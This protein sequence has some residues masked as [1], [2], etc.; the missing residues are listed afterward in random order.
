VDTRLKE[1]ELHMQLEHPDKSALAEHSIDLG[2]RIQ[3]YDTSI[4]ATK[5]RYMDHIIRETIEIELHPN[6]MDRDVGFCISKSWKPL[7]CREATV[8]SRSDITTDGQSVNMS[9]YRVHSGICDQILLSVRR[10]FS[11]ICFLSVWGA[12]SDERSGLLFVFHNLVIYQYLH[13]TFRLYVF[14][15]SA[16]YVQYI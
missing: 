2:H 7:M 1:H 6:N 11:E 4:L 9:R 14:Y 8:F 3:F 12:L 15:S 16:I 5:T 13:K 10:L